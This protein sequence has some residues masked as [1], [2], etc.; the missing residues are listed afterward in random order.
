VN[1]DDESLLCRD[2]LVGA[3]RGTVGASGVAIVVV[4]NPSIGAATMMIST[5]PMIGA[6]TRKP[7]PVRI[8]VKP[9]TV[10]HAVSSPADTNEVSV[11]I[12]NDSRHLHQAA[13]SNVVD[14]VLGKVNGVA[15]RH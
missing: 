4:V 13:V 10:A 7:V 9:H 3:A 15:G 5:T 14:Q 12:G 11:A 8:A 1:S 2:E 6:T